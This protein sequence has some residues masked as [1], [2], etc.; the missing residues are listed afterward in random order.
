[1]K[2]SLIATGILA[3]SLSCNTFAKV[4]NIS[5]FGPLE[6]KLQ[7]A[8]DPA[9]AVVTNN[10]EDAFFGDSLDGVGS[11]FVQ[12]G[13][14]CTTT[15]INPLQAITAAHCFGDP[16]GDGSAT[17]L[18]QGG[19]VGFG[20]AVIDNNSNTVFFDEVFDIAN[21][22]I[23]PL[24]LGATGGANNNVFGDGDIAVITF[25]SW[26][27][28]RSYY[29]LLLDNTTFE[30][31]FVPHVRVGRG[32]AGDLG[33][34]G[35]ADNIFDF[36]RRIGLNQ[37]DFFLSNFAGVPPTQAQGS[38]LLYDCDDGSAANDSFGAGIRGSLNQLGF[39]ASESCA[40]GGDS[41]SGNFI[42]D[43]VTFELTIVGVT[44][45]GTDD[46]QYGGFG[47][48]TR[49][50]SHAQ[51]LNSVVANVPVPATVGLFGLALAGL[52]GRKLLKK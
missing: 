33:V 5:E 8:G 30:E 6:H 29:D 1:M 49:T 40:D 27:G 24:W 42:V 44:S 23:N 15:L 48:D 45:F 7:V 32:T 10:N 12:G 20:D 3:A 13:G 25:D 51:W 50:A 18:S 37:Y 41:G 28:E 52:F 16:T 2:Y 17:G 34:P 39:G 11:L 22:D 31:L 4:M 38:R 21:V 36:Q 47:G 9:L 43:P 35:D 19:R 46:Q 26:V 14:F